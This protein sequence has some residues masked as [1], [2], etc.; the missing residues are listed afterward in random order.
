M[1]KQVRAERFVR[2]R[3]PTSIEHLARHTS[4]RSAILVAETGPTTRAW[5]G[6]GG[7]FT[8]DAAGLDRRAV[9]QPSST[10]GRLYADARRCPPLWCEMIA[11]A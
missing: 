7:I 1:R 9:A 10:I 2:T 8:A 3:E 6:R 4:C 5:F 11:L